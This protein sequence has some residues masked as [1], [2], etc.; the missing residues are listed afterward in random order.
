[1]TRSSALPVALCASV[2]FGAGCGP[3]APPAKAPDGTKVA[4]PDA[5][6]SSSSGPTAAPSTAKYD[7]NAW[8][9]APGPTPEEKTAQLERLAKDFGPLKSNWV[10][11]GKTE[12]YG[13]AEARLDAP[14]DVIRARLTDFVH[15][16]D[17]A[18]HRFK[19]VKVV[20]KVGDG[21]DIYFQLPIM[22][23]LITIWYVT[24][25]MPPRPGKGGTEIIEGT[26]VKGNVKDV[27]FVFTLLPAKEDKS[28]T[29][30]VCDLLLG[31]S[32]PAPQ[33]NVDEELRDACGEALHKTRMLSVPGFAPPAPPPP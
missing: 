1:M 29:V 24:R 30:V 11:P 28:S 5:P 10:P 23:G 31:L 22:K 4:M 19:S 9:Y 16:K 33:A 7:A 15:Y 6:A 18:G 20:D 27:H 3:E 26:F 17:L 12:R 8:P 32:V 14:Y 25:F 21:S 13:H 2:L